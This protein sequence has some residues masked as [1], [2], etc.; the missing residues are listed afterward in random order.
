MGELLNAAPT[1]CTGDSY[2]IIN[3]EF[4]APGF[5][6]RDL[7]IES[8]AVFH[9]NLLHHIGDSLAT[10]AA[11]LQTSV[12]RG[13]GK[14]FYRIGLLHIETPSSIYVET[15]TVLLQAIDLHNDF[16]EKR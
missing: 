10:V 8:S 11:S 1:K 6:L 2:E 14:D 3:R 9:Y 16:A 15:V 12:D 13:L 4:I 5:S 7:K